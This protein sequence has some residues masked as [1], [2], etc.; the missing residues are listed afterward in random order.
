MIDCL[1]VR[2]RLE[3]LVGKCK[4][5]NDIISKLTGHITNCHFKKLYKDLNM[6]IFNVDLSPTSLTVKE[7]TTINLQ[8]K[9]K[10]ETIYLADIIK[11][12]L[13]NENSDFNYI[14]KNSS[15]NRTLI[16][17]E[18]IIDLKDHNP[19]YLNISFSKNGKIDSFIDLYLV[20][21]FIFN[22]CKILLENNK[23]EKY[24]EW[25]NKFHKVADYITNE[26]GKIDAKI[27]RSNE[28]KRGIDE[29]LLKLK[30]Y[31]KIANK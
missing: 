27:V 30:C 24:S 29:T 20:N 6:D 7:S 25:M 18:L 10:L 22:N 21:Q 8:K 5:N 16:V 28:L 13:I 26:L 2:T 31:K 3:M 15:S 1:D 4:N 23:V 19:F 9:I 14:C 17:T 12:E 11:Y